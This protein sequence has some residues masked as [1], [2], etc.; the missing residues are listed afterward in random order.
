[1]F[2][3]EVF[4]EY[5]LDN[6]VGMFGHSYDFDPIALDMITDGKVCCICT[7]HCKG[8]SKKR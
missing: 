1:M 2:Q 8:N 4:K 6:G 5:F 3:I 7:G